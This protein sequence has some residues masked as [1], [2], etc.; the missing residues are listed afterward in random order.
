MIVCTGCNGNVY[1][2]HRGGFCRLCYTIK[3]NVMEY[4]IKNNCINHGDIAEMYN[5]NPEHLRNIIIYL[6]KEGYING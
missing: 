1:G 5:Y 6:K 4:Y 2:M 3:I